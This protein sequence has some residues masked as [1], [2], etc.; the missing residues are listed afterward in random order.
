ME[1]TITESRGRHIGSFAADT[2]GEAQKMTRLARLCRCPD[3]VLAT[4]ESRLDEYND[5]KSPA[6]P[7]GFPFLQAR[8]HPLQPRGKC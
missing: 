2:Y 5:R 1:R 4:P 6:E 3:R 7:T 8:H